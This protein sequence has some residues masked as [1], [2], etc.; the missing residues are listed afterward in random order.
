MVYN[1]KGEPI[2]TGKLI[3]NQRV[4]NYIKDIE[5]TE[6]ELLHIIELC[7][8]QIAIRKYKNAFEK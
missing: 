6:E 4:V 3:C 1:E 2:I 5:T 7:I 8:Q